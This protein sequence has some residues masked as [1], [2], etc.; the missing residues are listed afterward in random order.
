MFGISLMLDC[1]DCK[2]GVCDDM[3]LHYRFLEELVNRIG[4]TPMAPPVVIHAPVK[5]LT[6]YQSYEVRLQPSNTYLGMETETIK[7]R[8]EMY[9]D[10]AGISAWQCLVESGIQCHSIEPKHFMAMDLFTCGKLDVDEV[11][12]FTKEK[13]GFKSFEKVVLERGLKY[14]A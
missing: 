7:H 6:E 2:P 12:S 14:N 13:F 4:M 5:F 9:P 11:I 10:K 8:I 1:Y 3:E